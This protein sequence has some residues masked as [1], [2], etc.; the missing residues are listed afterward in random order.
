[1]K[2]WKKTVGIVVAVLAIYVAAA[3]LFGNEKECCLC[4][5]P[6]YSTPCLV[7][8]ETGDILQLPLDG[9]TTSGPEGQ[10]DVSTFS[11]IR[12]HTVTGTKQTS[13]N[14]IELKIPTD[15][16]VN[17]PALCSK[18]RKLLPQ[19]YDGRYALADLENNALLPIVDVVGYTIHS[20]RITTMLTGEC[21][22]LTIQQ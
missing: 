21:A 11:F 17:T 19:G 9:P 6:S 3:F 12:F 14:V 13:P 15:D 4:N 8:L 1:M 5:S 22:I 7:D 10:T 18:C 16:T 2:Q 20:Y